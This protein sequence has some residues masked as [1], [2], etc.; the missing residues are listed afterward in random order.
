MGKIKYIVIKSFTFILQ[1]FQNIHNGVTNVEFTNVHLGIHP[2]IQQDI[3][4]R[5][6]QHAL[7]YMNIIRFKMSPLHLET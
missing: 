4:S 7:W 1:Y 6:H 3:Q 2:N 5:I